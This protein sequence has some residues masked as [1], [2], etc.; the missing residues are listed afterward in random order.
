MLGGVPGPA[1]PIPEEKIA[2]PTKIDLAAIPIP[3]PSVEPPKKI[4]LE[5]KK[6]KPSATPR[7]KKQLRESLPDSYIALVIRGQRNL[8]DRCYGQHLRLNP[9]A[10]GRID[11]LLTIEPD[12][13]ISSARVVASSISDP[14]LQQCVI[15]VLQRAK[16]RPYDGDPIVVNYPINFE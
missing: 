13:T 6:A 7:P 11:T 14:V 2:K 1:I 10:R 15:T 9:Q 4:V 12:G 3:T 8:L 5:E 16:F